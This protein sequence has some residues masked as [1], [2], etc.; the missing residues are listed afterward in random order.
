MNYVGHPTQFFHRFEHA[1][2]IE[3]GSLGIVGI[4]GSVLVGAH[5]A[6]VEIIIVVDEIDLKARCLNGGH[7]DDE[8]VIGFVDGDVHPRQANH[9]VQLVAALIDVAPFRHE[10]ADFSPSLLNALRQLATYSGHLRLGNI[11][12]HFLSDVQDL[13]CF[14]SEN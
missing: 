12:N 3:D 13:F 6:F 10:G 11:G 9:F 1:T 4:F 2:R 8:R 5:Q 7:F 14:H